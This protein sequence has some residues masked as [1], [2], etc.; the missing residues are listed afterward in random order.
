[1]PKNLRKALSLMALLFLPAALFPIQKQL[2]FG[3]VQNYYLPVLM[4][5]QVTL[6]WQPFANLMRQNN[7]YLRPQYRTSDEEA[8]QAHR[9][10]TQG[11]LRDAWC[12]VQND[13]LFD[14]CSTYY[15]R[16]NNAREQN[17]YH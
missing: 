5:R 9:T 14:L 1:M 7:P 11:G 17:G 8:V 10:L 4:A 12:Q 16:V 13:R 6:L 15:N 3:P 2:N